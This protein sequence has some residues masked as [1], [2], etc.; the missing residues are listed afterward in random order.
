MNRFYPTAKA[1]TAMLLLCTIIA[2]GKNNDSAGGA[3]GTGSGKTSE[4]ANHTD[5][6]QKGDKSE[7]Q[8]KDEIG[9]DVRIPAKPQRIIG[10]YLEDELLSLG[11]QP[12]KQS[13]IGTWSG[14]DYLGLSIPSIDVNGS[15]EAVLE[16]A[17]DLILENVFDA[18]RYD[19]FSKVAPMY[20]FKDARA[21][22]RA[23]IRTLGGLF[24]RADKAEEVIKQYD[25]R[26]NELGQ[27]I[28]NR[29]GNETV[30]ILRVHTKEIR[31]YG[32]PGYAG[33][34]VYQDLGLTPSKLVRELILDKDGK[35]VPLSME[36]IPKLDADHIFVTKDTGA[37]DKAAELFN[38]PLWKLVPAVQKGH[39]Y[40]VN[41]ETWMKSGPIADSKKMDDVLEALV[42]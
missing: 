36:M 34:V 22:W 16:A 33:P 21:D 28:K 17:P 5:A 7:R 20:A 12:I 8:V 35:V 9:H 31:L 26:G 25:R 1:V 3:N 27:T 10:I 38:N 4:P 24:D 19:Q 37:E 6:A 42:K 15:V 39:V 41:F 2:C 40:E 13:R 29:I 11:I 32:G 18:K 30:A 14:Q 23:T